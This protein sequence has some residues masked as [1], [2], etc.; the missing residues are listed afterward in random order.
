MQQTDSKKP[1]TWFLREDGRLAMSGYPITVT[2]L[3]D[4]RTICPFQLRC[5]GRAAMDY[6]SLDEAK[7]TAER[8]A[9]EEDEFTP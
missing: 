1:R 5:E 4:D 3:R 8:W 7:R 2:R 9:D 6:F